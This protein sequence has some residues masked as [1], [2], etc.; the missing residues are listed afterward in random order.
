MPLLRGMI[1]QDTFVKNF[2]DDSKLPH[3]LEE[4]KKY[5]M[6]MVGFGRKQDDLH[7]D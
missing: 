2:Y 7:S 5:R 3:S 1:L 4:C 6:E